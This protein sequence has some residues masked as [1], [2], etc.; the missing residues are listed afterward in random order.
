MVEKKAVVYLNKFE[1]D[2]FSRC[3]YNNNLFAEVNNTGEGY[4]IVTATVTKLELEKIMY[5][6]DK[7]TDGYKIK[8]KLQQVWDNIFK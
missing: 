7:Q 2:I 1:L 5:F 8:L 6:L 3:C 4:H